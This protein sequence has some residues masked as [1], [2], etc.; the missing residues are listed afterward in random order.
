MAREQVDRVE[1][2]THDDSSLD[3]A[4]VEGPNISDAVQTSDNQIVAETVVPMVTE[5]ITFSRKESL[6]KQC[7]DLEIQQLCQLALDE[8][9]ID[10]IS[11]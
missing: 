9:K 7:S 3:E 4:T 10:T 1:D 11:E 6:Q 2:E 8:R 5:G